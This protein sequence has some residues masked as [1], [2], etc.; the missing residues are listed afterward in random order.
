LHH[1]IQLGISVIP[2]SSNPQRIRENI[3][4][5]DFKL[6]AQEMQL[7]DSIQEDFRLFIFPL[8]LAHPWYP[9]K[10]GN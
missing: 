5:F 9:F 4:I 3:D 2:K 1:L 8:G 7:F 10:E 6:T